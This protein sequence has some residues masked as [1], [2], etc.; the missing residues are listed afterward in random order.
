MPE[1]QPA[2]GPRRPL[3]PALALALGIACAATALA[4]LVAFPVPLVD[5]L[6]GTVA[7]AAVIAAI[8]LCGYAAVA[9]RGRARLAAA[10]GVVLAAYPLALQ[11]PSLVPHGRS[12]ADARVMSLNTFFGM[13]DL[14]VAARTAVEHDVDVVAL[15]ECAGDCVRQSE[16][17]F[18]AVGYRKVGVTGDPGY[19]EVQGTVVLA[20]EGV[21]VT[22]PVVPQPSGGPI[23]YGSAQ[24]RV[25]K[26]ET[27]F[28]LVAMHFTNPLTT[29][30]TWALDQTRA[31]EVARADE[32]VLMVGDLNTTPWHARYGRLLDQG[33]LTSCERRLGTG[34]SGTWG[35]VRAP[36][37]LQV[38]H[39]LVR[40]LTCADQSHVSVPGSDHRAVVTGVSA[41]YG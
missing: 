5:G 31:A 20:R 32:P 6:I 14:S 22:A 7:P 21:E 34:L 25:T 3:L 11:A 36:W 18:A 28:R 27:S 9:L 1:T 15:L 24:V 37:L 17:S 12:R 23:G 8:L 35:L 4:S 29:A 10:L 33:G 41:G 40:G 2:R 39:A 16:K 26:G 38:D 19:T 30:P 13:A